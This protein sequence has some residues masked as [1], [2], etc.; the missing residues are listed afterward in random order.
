M[1]AKDKADQLYTDM[2]NELYLLHSMR[3]R[4]AKQCALIAANELANFCT[5]ESSAKEDFYLDVIKELKKI[6]NEEPT[7]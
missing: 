2:Y 3:P 6:N 7:T 1:T 4:I 5:I